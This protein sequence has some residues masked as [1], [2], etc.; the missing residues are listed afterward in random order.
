MDK[1][2]LDEWTNIHQING[3]MDKQRQKRENLQYKTTK[4]H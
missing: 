3:K 1:Q 4:N 2:T